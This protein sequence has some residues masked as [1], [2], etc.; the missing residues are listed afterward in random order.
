M[1][2]LGLDDDDEEED[3]DDDDDEA[4]DDYDFEQGDMDEGEDQDE[5]DGDIGG[6]GDDDDDDEVYGGGRKVD[7]AKLREYAEETGEELLLPT[8]MDYI[9]KLAG[10]DE[11]GDVIS[12]KK[13]N[14][15]AEE[16]F[17]NR[18][19]TDK[20]AFYGTNYADHDL[21]HRK[22]E[23][24][25]AEEEEQEA[26]RL[27]RLQA[28]ALQE[29]DFDALLP[30][31]AKDAAMS[32]KA[33]G[34]VAAA[35][36]VG[37]GV[38]SLDALDHAAVHVKRDL[39]DLDEAQKLKLLR[40]ALPELCRHTKYM[41]EQVLR[42]RNVL[43]PLMDRLHKLSK[44]A[45]PPQWAEYV[46]YQYNLATA[47]VTN[48][49]YMVYAQARGTLTR[50]HPCYTACSA[51]KS[52]LEGSSS[53]RIDTALSSVL[54]DAADLDSL[55]ANAAE[56]MLSRDAAPGE[57][58]PQ[59]TEQQA[60][61]KKEKARKRKQNQREKKK[62]L[63]KLGKPAPKQGKVATNDDE[64]DEGEDIDEAALN[65]AAMEFYKRAEKLSVQKKKLQAEKYV[66]FFCLLPLDCL[67]TRVCIS[68][69]LLRARALSL[70]LSFVFSFSFFF[71]FSFSNV[72]LGPCALVLPVVL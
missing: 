17:L 36:G 19:G 65:A 63:K 45:E 21:R 3:D 16:A 38:Q 46:Q 70:S 29:D 57:N 59:L 13:S 37:G 7:L 5:E 64:G 72:G 12:R 43:S 32:G 18:W 35:G 71:S 30:S 24:E 10:Y 67:H 44:T 68:L 4:G 15:E 55:P 50:E 6:D 66:L 40:K 61:K 31:A 8:S 62:Q 2:V 26:M 20:S 69:C 14:D 56:A 48:V 34:A 23:L 1:G 28:E 53:S 27:Q 52:G 22:E 51:L 25:E 60:L 11:H 58:K 42:L 47:Y 9:N 49:T 54:A 39:S 33:R 41:Q